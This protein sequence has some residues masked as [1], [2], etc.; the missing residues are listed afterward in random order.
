M[1]VGS[2][3]GCVSTMDGKS[4]AGQRCGSWFAVNCSAGAE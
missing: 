4:C 1:Y 2:P 3:H